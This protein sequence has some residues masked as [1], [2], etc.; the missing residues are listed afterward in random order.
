MFWAE[1]GVLLPSKAYFTS[2]DARAQSWFLSLMCTGLFD[3]GSDYAT[4]RTSYNSGLV[5]QVLEGKGYVLQGGR[6]ASLRAG[7]FCLVDCFSPHSYGT[8]TGW[9][10]LWA[11][12]A[13]AP[14]RSICSSIQGTALILHPQAQ[15]L[16]MHRRLLSLYEQFEGGPQLDDAEVH[17]A[18]TE[19]ITPFFQSRHEGEPMN[20]DR[21]AACLSEHL[22]DGISN[23]E[24][25]RM[26]HMSESQ[27]IRVFQQRKGTTPHRYLLGLRLSAAQ[28]YLASSDLTLA[29]I[30]AQCGFTDASALTN[31]F[32]RAFGTTPREYALRMAGPQP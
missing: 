8:Q 29:Q 11:H 7:D 23:A 17:C 24:L 3:C 19:L 31:S 22:A 27:F 9:K 16:H 26:A 5:M 30:A 2:P 12:F 15:G 10:I 28:Y 13:G 1:K 14:A 4:A 25:A 32:R 18:F 6:R 21:I 20:M